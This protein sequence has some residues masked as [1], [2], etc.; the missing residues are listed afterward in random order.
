MSFRNILNK[1]GHKERKQGANRRAS[2][3]AKLQNENLYEF[4]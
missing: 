2:I 1:W 3:S 4:N